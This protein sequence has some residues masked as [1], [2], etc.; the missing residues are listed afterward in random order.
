MKSVMRCNE[1]KELIDSFISD[2][3]L[4]ETNHDLLRHLADC[5]G[6][7]A[8]LAARRELRQRVRTSVK[9]ATAYRVDPAFKTRLTAR[10]RGRTRRSNLFE[11]FRIGRPTFAA[12]GLSL[13]ILAGV[14]GYTLVSRSRPGETAQGLDSKPIGP[15]IS[16]AI[17]ASW[18]ELTN[19]AVGDHENC[20]VDYKL[21]EDPIT[22]DQAA[23]KYGEFER[24]LDKVVTAALEINSRSNSD[25]QLRLIEAHSC[26][27][28]GRRFSHIV[29]KQGNNLIS[30]LVTNTET[31]L[32]QGEVVTASYEANVSSAGMSFGRHA[33]F[34]VSNLSENENA[35]L[36]KTLGRSMR[37]HAEKMGA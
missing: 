37:L 31:P 27:F 4:V 1:L 13:L 20:A 30:V 28:E 19:N 6:C 34:V 5:A 7:R 2:E 24:G 36:A 22:L 21:K 11:R 33:M 8:D 32:G 26:I 3:L 23:A 12:V 35:Q 18:Q 25:F 29:L 16:D 10:L 17:R 14:G 9:Q 15:V